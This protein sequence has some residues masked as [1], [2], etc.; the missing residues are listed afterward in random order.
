MRAAHV[1]DEVQ[2]RDA[3]AFQPRY[4][5]SP[6]GS[7]P[8]LMLGADGQR[9][10]RT[11]KWGLVPSFTRLEA[12][13][14]PD[15]YRMFNARCES[16]AQKS[17]FSR[18]LP[19]RRCVVLLDGF[20]EWKAEA[21]GRKQPF[22]ISTAEGPQQPAMY[23]AGLYDTYTDANGETMYTVTIVTTDSS[24]PLVWLHCRMPV[25][26]TTQE[27]VAEWLGEGAETAQ[28]HGNETASQP[29]STSCAS[30]STST[31]SQGGGGGD[32]VPSSATATAACTGG[33]LGVK[34]EGKPE[35][36]GREPESQP[37]KAEHGVG[38]KQEAGKASGHGVHLEESGSKHGGHA[39]PAGGKGGEGGEAKGSSRARADAAALVARL[40][41][42]YG[43][44][45]LKWHPVTPEMGKPSYDKP[46]CCMDVRSKKGSINA[47]FKS[48]A[49]PTPKPGTAAPKAVKSSAPS[50]SG[51]RA[52]SVGSQEA[53]AGARPAAGGGGVGA[54]AEAVRNPDECAAAG[55]GG[56]GHAG[57][58][59]QGGQGKGTKRRGPPQ[60]GR[61]GATAKRKAR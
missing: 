27:E 54:A 8:V 56:E 11:C 16:L 23:L 26:L 22:H 13:Q 18:L 61:H 1:G 34:T 35:P 15:F 46:D 14:R 9:E 47:F 3:A 59:G 28:G 2:W 31:S 51:A 29:H 53:A 48:A 43:G 24:K 39:S 21:G 57:G 52:S 5:I 50:D 32:D 40:C 42:P 37:P 30:V 33:E 55:T 20:Y 19:R 49:K 7:L 17:V 58:N 25:I 60:G 44:P 12:G 41:R 4:N 38:V 36:E 6:G 10:L 45:L